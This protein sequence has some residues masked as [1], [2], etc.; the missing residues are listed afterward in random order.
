MPIS[1]NV[2]RSFR[3]RATAHSS[4]TARTEHVVKILFATTEAVPFC[5]TGGLG[6][7]CGSLP[8][9]LA[10]LG[11]EPVVIMPAFRQ[12]LNSGRPIE[13][14]GMRFEIPI[15]R[16][17]VPGTF[18]RSTLPGDKVPVYLVHQPQY[19]DRPE[20]YRENGHD[21]KDNCERF[22][23]FCRAVLEAIHAARL[24]HRAGP[25]PRLDDRA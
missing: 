13:P 18:L 17:T 8:L 9:E 3:S 16:K 14:T 4:T 25:L 24:G 20:L 22:V 1:L 19:Y 11:H 10:K 7:V 5:K 21:Y 12:A 23:F 6:D 2:L 15:G